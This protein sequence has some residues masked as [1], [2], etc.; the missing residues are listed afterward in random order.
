MRRHHVLLVE[1]QLELSVTSYP[2]REGRFGTYHHA[3]DR[4]VIWILWIIRVL[5]YHLEEVLDKIIVNRVYLC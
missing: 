5:L 4:I 3:N 2:P 1:D